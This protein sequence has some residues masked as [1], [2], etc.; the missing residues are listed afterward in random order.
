MGFGSIII[1]DEI[2]SG[3]RQ[4]KHFATVVAALGRRGLELSW[5][6]YLGDEPDRIAAALE[7]AYA[8]GDA[9]FSFGGIGATPD[10]HTRQA[11]AS[12][13]GVALE[14]HPDAEREIR[15]RKQRGHAIGVVF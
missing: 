15:E 13:A 5:S 14:L 2:L 12:A 3:K 6:T 4:D 11:A 1:G 7:R 9:V 8:S 10:D